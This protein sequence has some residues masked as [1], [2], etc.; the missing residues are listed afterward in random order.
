MVVGPGDVSTKDE[1]RE[2][3]VSQVGV[4]LC[5]PWESEHCLVVLGHS[6]LLAYFIVL[7]EV[8]QWGGLGHVV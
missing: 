8:M 1:T 5:V 2:G 7:Q 6:V 3:A 4:V